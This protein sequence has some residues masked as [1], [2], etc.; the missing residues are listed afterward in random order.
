MFNVAMSVTAC[1][2]ANTRVDVAWVLG[3]DG[4][5][6]DPATDAVAFT[7]GGGRIGGILDGAADSPLAAASPGELSTGR[8]VTVELTDA[9]AA[10]AGRPHGGALRCALVPAGQ[11][12]EA[13]WPALVAREPVCLVSAVEGTT[14]TATTLYS[15]EDVDAAGDEIAE[16]F[17]SGASSVTLSDDTVVTVLHPVPRLVVSGGGPI[18]D[19]LVAAAAPLGWQASVVGNTQTAIG[20]MTGLSALD[21]A[22]VIGHDVESSSRV[23]AAAL[24]G[25]AG[26]IGA[27]GSLQMQQNRA[28]WLAYRG[29]T[30]LTRVHGPA[31][32][33]IGAHTP[34]EIALSILAEAVAARRRGTTGADR[35]RLVPLEAAHQEPRG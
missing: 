5:A 21:S 17:R 24:E 4:L 33:D 3:S 6:F 22:V 8:I 15:V 10:M 26:Y 12:P 19:A 18:A 27:V 2:N 29:I 7:P 20:M 32:I 16:R 25:G 23:L 14:I 30:D 28:D 11:L 31:G 35:P 13:L 1:L 9:E 34:G